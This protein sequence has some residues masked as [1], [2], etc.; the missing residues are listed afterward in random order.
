MLAN[1]QSIYN[2]FAQ[3]HA[4]LASAIQGQ[5]SSLT[6][7]VQNVDPTTA[8]NQI[9]LYCK[10]DASNVPQMFFRPQ[11]N[12]TPI[13]MTNSSIQNISGG[14]QVSFIAGPFTIYMG[15]ILEVNTPFTVN[16]TPAKQLLYAGITGLGNFSI[17]ATNL[18]VGTFVASLAGGAVAKI[19]AYYL[20]IGV[21]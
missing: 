9:A 6:M 5:H 17:I 11:S 20:A 1:F 3:N 8:A 13:Q 15:Y 4:A 14:N 21:N 10:L 7:R 12:A 2:S 19:R 16:L 18:G